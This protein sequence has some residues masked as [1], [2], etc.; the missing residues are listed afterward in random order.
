MH[1]APVTVL[2]VLSAATSALGATLALD[3]RAQLLQ[4]SVDHF[5]AAP[6][7]AVV[8]ASGDDAKFGTIVFKTMLEMGLDAVPVNP[9]APSSAGHPCVPSLEDL[10]NPEQT[11]VSIVTQPA[12]TLAILHQAIALGVPAVWLQPGA[13][14]AAV[15]E[16]I[17]S[18]RAKGSHTMFIH[19]SANYTSDDRRRDDGDNGDDV[20][21][22]CR[23]GARSFETPDLISTL[24]R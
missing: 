16:F 9:Y 18:A 8:G 3:P 6:R 15:L 12:V 22:T 2:A 10:P 4:Q 17:A 23:R 20:T 13:E 21:P 14:D 11:S 1:F 24:L 19:S 7:F 5:L